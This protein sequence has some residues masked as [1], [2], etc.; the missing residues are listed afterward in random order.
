MPALTVRF[1]T[2]A[3]FNRSLML[4]AVG[5]NLHFLLFQCHILYYIWCRVVSSDDTKHSLNTHRTVVSDIWWHLPHFTSLSIISGQQF[6]SDLTF[7]Y[8]RIWILLSFATQLRVESL[9]GVDVAS[10]PPAVFLLPRSLPLAQSNPGRSTLC[11]CSQRKAIAWHSRRTRAV[12]RLSDF[13]EWYFC[14]K[15]GDIPQSVQ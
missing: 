11:L 6:Y 1:N 5:S 3:T 12:V 8:R 14:V 2:Y 15:S 9:S 13:C 7:R 10:S 4:L